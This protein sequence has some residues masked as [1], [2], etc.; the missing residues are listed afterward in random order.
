MNVTE[1]EAIVVKDIPYYQNSSGG[2]TISGGEPLLQSSFLKNL[3]GKMQQRTIQ[4][5]MDF[6]SPQSTQRPQRVNLLLHSTKIF[7]S[8]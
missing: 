7:F 6:P 3:L 2:V 4:T 8:V 1:I 5:A